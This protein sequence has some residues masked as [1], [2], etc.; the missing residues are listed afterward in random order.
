MP[1]TIGKEFMQLTRYAHLDPSAQS[2]GVPIPP[3]E[4]A[5][6]PTAK[7]VDL[8]SPED[9]HVP[10][11]DLRTAI[12][13]RRSLRK[14]AEQAL[15][16]SELSFLLWCTQGV[17]H[18]TE[19][20]VTFRTVPSAGA[21]HAFE[22]FVLVN[23]VEGLT[24][25]LYRYTALEHA[26]LEVDL[27]PDIAERAAHACLEQNMVA[28]AAVSFFWVAVVERMKW[29]YG[30]RGYRYLHLDAGHVCQNLCLAA[31]AI[32]SGA[33]AI[34]AFDDDLLNQV[35]GADGE[36]MFAVYAAALGKKPAE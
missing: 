4:L 13:Q 20:P 30:E 31:E 3:L 24:P 10:G 29:R 2:Q 8:P 1:N 17:K 15:S 32:Q 18:V 16:L 27:T 9:T 11:I 6:P 21:R 23:R 22:T 35:V 14:Y 28:Q 36:A 33:C 34:A 25:G 19:R 7:L 26:L 12:E 5:F